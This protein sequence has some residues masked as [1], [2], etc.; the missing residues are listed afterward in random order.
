M[1]SLG[2]HYLLSA[3]RN[4]YVISQL[5]MVKDNKASYWWAIPANREMS[6]VAHIGQNQSCAPDKIRDAERAQCIY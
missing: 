4:S 1:D 5:R 3:L 2:A 6:S